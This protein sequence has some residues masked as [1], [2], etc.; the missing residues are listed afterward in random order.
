MTNKHNA[1]T[2]AY[3]LLLKERH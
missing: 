1:V 2:T 3:Y